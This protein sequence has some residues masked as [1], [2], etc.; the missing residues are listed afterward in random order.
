MV[1]LINEVEPEFLT[2]KH[3]FST[4]YQHG[5]RNQLICNLMSSQIITRSY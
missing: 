3:R 5:F 1:E 4:V 2:I